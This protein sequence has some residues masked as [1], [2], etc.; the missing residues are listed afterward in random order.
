M[1]TNNIGILI[2]LRYEGKERHNA[3]NSMPF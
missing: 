3:L 2:T 1:T